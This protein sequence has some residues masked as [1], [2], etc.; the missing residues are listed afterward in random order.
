MPPCVPVP[1][2]MTPD[3]DPAIRRGPLVALPAQPTGVPWPDGGWPTSEATPPELGPLVD[4]TFN[5]TA[6]F[7]TTYAVVVVHKGSIVAERYGG[8]LPNWSG[9]DIEVTPDTPLLSW[10]MAKSIT[11]AAVGVLVR[12][13]RLDLTAPAPVAEWSGDTRSA[14]TID[15]LMQ[16]R[17]GLEFV[18]DYLDDGVSNVIEM[19]FG[20]GRDDVAAYAAARPVAH[21]PGSV[22]NY[23]SGTSNIVARIVGDV[24]GGGEEGLRRFLAD[25]LFDAIGMASADPRFDAAGT[26]VGSSYVYATAHDFA[27]FGLLYLRGGVWDGRQ[28]LPEGWV[29]HARLPRSVDATDGRIY[30]A[31][32]WVVGDE[33]G[34]FWASGYEGQMLVCVPALD[35]V[36]ARLGR[37]DASLGPNL[38]DWRARV[39]EAFA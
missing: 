8:A 10:S 6:R 2:V 32:W 26:F 11:H 31:H 34:S 36:I 16:M 15:A 5:D 28:I 19:L 30:G 7:G 23:S 37:T 14:I 33:H 22:F 35:L 25:E 12:D 4:A 39:T 1:F 20:A 29:D 38:F 18:E 21:A 24:V 17:D 9:S 3:R 13:E 27:R